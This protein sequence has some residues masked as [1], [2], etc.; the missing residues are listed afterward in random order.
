MEG[1]D[2]EVMG[3]GGFVEVNLGCN[4][5]SVFLIV[6]YFCS[7]FFFISFVCYYHHVLVVYYPFFG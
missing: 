6:V 4:F 3:S 1:F 5:L 7:F 2:I